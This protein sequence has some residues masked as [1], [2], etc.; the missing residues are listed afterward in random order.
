M[1]SLPTN[2]STVRP[3]ATLK[4]LIVRP[5]RRKLR[6]AA[7]LFRGLNFEL[8]LKHNTQFFWVFTRRRHFRRS[9]ALPGGATGWWML[10]QGLASWRSFA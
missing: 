5:G 9:G 4:N 2:Q 8:D 10:A 3:L 6:V 1:V 7:G